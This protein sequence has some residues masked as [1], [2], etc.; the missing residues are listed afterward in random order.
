MGILI[1]ATHAD[2]CQAG[3]AKRSSQISIEKHKA[4]LLG[5]EIFSGWDRII[6]SKSHR[7]LSVASSVG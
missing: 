6:Q 5:G 7:S 1:R 3:N 2:Q 4:D